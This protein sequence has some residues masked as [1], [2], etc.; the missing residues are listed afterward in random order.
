MNDFLIIAGQSI[1]VLTNS[2]KENA[3]SRGGSEG[4]SYN[5]RLR[6]TVRWSKRSWTFTSAAIQKSLGETLKTATL[7]GQLVTIG[8]TTA[9]PTPCRVSIGDGTIINCDSDDENHWMIQYDIAILEP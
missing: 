1:P 7:L 6:S 2:F 9:I 4:R 3:P 8:G 5:G